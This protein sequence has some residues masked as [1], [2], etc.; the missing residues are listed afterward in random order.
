MLNKLANPDKVVN[1]PAQEKIHLL[2][3]LTKDSQFM[4]THNIMD[5]S[6]FL[7]EAGFKEQ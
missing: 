4:K 5:Y 3:I 2:E 1:V 6:L 7:I